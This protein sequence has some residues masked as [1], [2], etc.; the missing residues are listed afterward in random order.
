MASRAYPIKLG[1]KVWGTGG[2]NDWF[3]R[4]MGRDEQ[5]ELFTQST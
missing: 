1:V 5:N 3:V 2:K 4:V